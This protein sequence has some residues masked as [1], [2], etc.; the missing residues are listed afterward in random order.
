MFSCAC[1]GSAGPEL[2]RATKEGADHACVGV[3]R[4]HRDRVRGLL[5]NHE[6]PYLLI[7]G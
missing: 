7:S 3:L 4:G 1:V 6:V 5:W 2:E